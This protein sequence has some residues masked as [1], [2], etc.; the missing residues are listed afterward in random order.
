MM[1]G[2]DN[3]TAGQFRQDIQEIIRIS[4]DQ[5]A[6]YPIVQIKGVELRHDSLHAFD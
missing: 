1:A 2:L 6:V 5:L 4:P 3:Q